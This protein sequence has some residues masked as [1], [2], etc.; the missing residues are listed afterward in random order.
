MTNETKNTAELFDRF[1]DDYS[2]TVDAALGI[3]GLSV[4]FAAKVKAD[5]L[6][7]VATSHFGRTNCLDV[8]DIGCGIGNYHQ[9]LRPYFRSLTGIDISKESLEIARARNADV[10][11]ALYDGARLPCEDATFDLLF[12]IC[13]MH[14]V[15]PEA[16]PDFVSE[17]ARVLRPGG[18]FV[19]FEHNPRNPLTRRIVDRCPFDEDAVL[20]ARE[21]IE[22]LFEGTGLEDVAGRYILTIPAANGPLRRLDGVFD[23]LSLGAQYYVKGIKR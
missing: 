10:T 18:L 14:H 15:P 22:R 11:Y 1:G 12:A 9:R 5:Y 7:D 13:V 8:A 16:W 4:D 20:L 17:A 21:E 3:P 23:R 6:R 2:R 19:V